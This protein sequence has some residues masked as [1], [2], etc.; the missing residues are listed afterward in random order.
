[1]GRTDKDVQWNAVEL[2][3][4]DIKV[5]NCATF[6]NNIM[7]LCLSSIFTF[8]LLLLLLPLPLP[9][10]LFLAYFVFCLHRIK[11]LARVLLHMYSLYLVEIS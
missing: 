8:L 10:Q 4:W 2:W 7:D 3:S 9:L 1:M 11:E 5:N 6:R